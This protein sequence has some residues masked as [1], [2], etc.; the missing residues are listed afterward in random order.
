LLYRFFGH[1]L[2]AIPM[3]RVTMQ[4]AAS[5]DQLRCFSALLGWP[6]FGIA[7]CDR[8]LRFRAVNQALADM[9][10]LPI[11]D[12]IGKPL[13]QVIGDVAARVQPAFEQVLSTG[14]P[15]V[16]LEVTAQLPRKTEVGHWVESLYPI[17]DKNGKVLRVSAVILETTRSKNIEQ[18]IYHLRW[19]LQQA[20]H[21]LQLGS[22]YPVPESQSELASEGIRLLEGCVRQTHSLAESIRSVPFVTTRPPEVQNDVSAPARNGHSRR[23]SPRERDIIQL[24]A[25]G[26][27]N[28][29]MSSILQIS[30]R[31]VESHRAR[32]MLKLGVSSAAGLVRYAFRNNFV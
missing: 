22:S 16:N 30:I 17:K 15:V 25:Q 3:S 31:T 32:L 14:K 28:K 13:H 18:S 20:I 29:Q 2:V 11:E 7:I 5:T 1:F 24:L 9:N 4:G 21:T 23:L 26:K 27:S 12:H 19:R 6:T 8:K 10:G